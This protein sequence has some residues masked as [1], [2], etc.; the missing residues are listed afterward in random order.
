V[1]FNAIS[2]II[3]DIEILK[4]KYNNPYDVQGYHYEQDCPVGADY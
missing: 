2:R 3:N 4:L 1:R